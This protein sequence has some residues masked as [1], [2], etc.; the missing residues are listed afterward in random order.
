MGLLYLYAVASL[1]S[2]QHHYWSFVSLVPVVL[3]AVDNTLVLFKPCVH[4]VVIHINSMTTC[5][6]HSMVIYQY[7][8]TES[9]ILFAACG[10]FNWKL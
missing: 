5:S 1:E 9:L 4:F 2:D 10:Y 6:P 8:N 7:L 3:S